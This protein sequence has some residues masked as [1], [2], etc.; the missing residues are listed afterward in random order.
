[1]ITIKLGEEYQVAELDAAQLSE[2]LAIFHEKPHR[3]PFRVIHLAFEGATPPKS[4][5]EVGKIEC[6]IGEI[7]AA[8]Q[9]IF[10]RSVAAISFAPAMTID[11]FGRRWVVN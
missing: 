10:D 7:A 3:A 1:M 2:V 4:R 8:A 9:E 11:V 6:P 5:A